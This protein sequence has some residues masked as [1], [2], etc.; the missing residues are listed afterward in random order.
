VIKR[1]NFTGRKRVPSDHVWI[2]VRDGSPRPFDARITL[3]TVNLPEDAAVY[4]EATCAGTSTVQRYDFG[5]VGSIHARD[6]TVLEDLHGENVYFSLK[7]VDTSER[8]GRI[9][10]FADNLRPQKAGDQT[11]TGRRGILPVEQ[12]DLGQQLWQLE[13]RQHDV[14]LLVN[15]NVPGL[16]DRLGADPAFYGLVY[17]EIIRTVLRRALAEINEPEEG[18]DSWPVLWLRFGRNTHPEFE[19]PPEADDETEVEA[20][21]EAIVRAFCDK[22]EIAEAFKRAVD[23]EGGE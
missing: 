8:F 4:L 1:F 19:R 18:D 12:V 3:D 23:W 10:G 16:A 14:T 22:H 6:E 9:V 13:F 17:P 7:V 20:W 11:A 2:E 15:K 5:R 21:I